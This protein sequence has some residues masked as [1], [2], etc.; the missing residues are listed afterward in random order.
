MEA[1]LNQFRLFTVAGEERAVNDRRRSVCPKESTSAHTGSLLTGS[2][3][4]P[5]R[6]LTTTQGS[7][8][9]SPQQPSMNPPGASS[10]SRSPTCP[11]GPA[12]DPAAAADSRRAS[13]EADSLSSGCAGSRNGGD[14]SS[15]ECTEARGQNKELRLD[16]SDAVMTSQRGADENALIGEEGDGGGEEG[17]GAGAGAAEK[18]LVAALR[19]LER[20]INT[21]CHL[22]NKKLRRERTLK[23]PTERTVEP[24]SPKTSAL[25]QDKVQNCFGY[26]NS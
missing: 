8:S 19:A 14:R 5:L 23:S 6:A 16:L 1:N 13:A 12:A 7:F 4:P 17:G 15:A 25:R 10:F 22:M 2:M 11:A 3:N 24:V 20:S 26:Y 21:Q 18:S 9:C